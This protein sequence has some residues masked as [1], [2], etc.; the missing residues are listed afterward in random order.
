MTKKASVR[1]NTD[2]CERVKAGFYWYEDCASTITIL[3]G[4]LSRKDLIRHGTKVGLWSEGPPEEPARVFLDV[5]EACHSDLG[6]RK[7]V[8]KQINR[9]FPGLMQKVRAADPGRLAKLGRETEWPIHLLWACLNDPREETRAYGRLLTHD[10]PWTAVR[11][12]F[13][14]AQDHLDHR[15]LEKLREK[16]RT[17]ALENQRLARCLAKDGEK[18]KRFKKGFARSTEA[19]PPAPVPAN[20]GQQREIRKLRYALEKAEAELVLLQAAGEDEACSCALKDE[21]PACEDGGDEGVCDRCRKAENCRDC[22]LKG[23]RV[24]II[25]GLDRM[26]GTYRQVVEN[27]GGSFEFHCG[28]VKAGCRKVQGIVNRSD[29][30]VFMTTINSHA[31]LKVTK[32]FCKKGCKKFITLKQRGVDSLERTLRQASGG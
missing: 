10:L 31:A 13:V 24:A 23:R 17:L 12:T 8:S 14:E 18:L 9:R 11:E 4:C 7:A 19:S 6:L 22:P 5:H 21:S 3:S 27:L 20:V 28:R 16:N 2:N 29:Y 25:G 30:V 32:T 26:E 15:D 1:G